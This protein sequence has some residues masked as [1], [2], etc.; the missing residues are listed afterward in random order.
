MVNILES[1]DKDNGI[2]CIS[3]EENDSVSKHHFIRSYRQRAS[4]AP[5]AFSVDIWV[6][7]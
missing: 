1:T 4:K 7:H 2:E 5:G 3:S 6:S